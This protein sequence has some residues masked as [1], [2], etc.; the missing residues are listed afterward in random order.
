MERMLAYKPTLTVVAYW[1]TFVRRPIKIFIG[2]IRYSY[3][4]E[5]GCWFCWWWWS[6][7]SFARLIT[8][9]FTTT[10]IKLSSNKIQNADILVSANPVH[11]EKWPLKWR[12]R[13]S[14]DTRNV[15]QHQPGSSKSRILA[16]SKTVK[17]LEILW[18]AENCGNQHFDFGCQ[19]LSI[20]CTFSPDLLTV[21]LVS[22]CVFWQ[23]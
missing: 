5:N 3:C 12:E 9:I 1:P 11:L 23:W 22:V 19:K 13:L 4:P 14:V 7:W 16:E 2:L 18:L 6:D 8:A 10:S 17:L 15:S 20:S 21:L